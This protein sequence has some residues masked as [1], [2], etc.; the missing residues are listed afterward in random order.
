MTT[1]LSLSISL[2]DD[3]TF[4]NFLTTGESRAQAKALLAGDHQLNMHLVY[5]WGALGTGVSHFVQAACHETSRQNKTV[6]YLPLAELSA[7][8]VELLLDGLEKQSLVCLEGIEVI[9]GDSRWEQALF[10]FYNKMI[11]LDHQILV[12]SDRPPGS[13][14]LQLPDLRSR[15]SS[16]VS[17]HF[18]PYSDGDKSDILI[19]RAA[20]L[21]I[22][23]TEEVAKFIVFRCSREMDDLMIALQRLDA[24]SLE[25]KRRI[26]IPFIKTIF[27]W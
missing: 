9:C 14:P 23:I 16:G 11:S 6:Q 12:T 20:R 1:Q 15:F 13:L 2:R 18:P 8:N 4:A 21:G 3:A 27:D 17:F 24:A 5:V 10:N 19:F 26:T 22:E 7:V 25:A